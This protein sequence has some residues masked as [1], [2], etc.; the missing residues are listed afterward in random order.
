MSVPSKA[1]VSATEAALAAAEKAS[2]QPTNRGRLIGTAVH[3]ESDALKER[4]AAALEK[5]QTHERKEK[6]M[7]ESNSRHNPAPPEQPPQPAQQTRAETHA[8]CSAPDE[9]GADAVHLL[10]LPVDLQAKILSALPLRS[11]PR[12]Q[13]TCRALKIAGGCSLEA[14]TVLDADALPAAHAEQAVRWLRASRCALRCVRLRARATDGCLQALTVQALSTTDGSASKER[15]GATA[16]ALRELDLGGAEA[17]T[18][19]AL[20]GL[21]GAPDLEKLVL[22]NCRALT[23]RGVELATPLPALT[24]LDLGGTQ[25]GEA[26]TIALARGCPA[27]TS[28]SLRGCRAVGDGG[29]SALGG[30]LRAL[31]QLDL[32]NSALSDEGLAALADGCSALTNLN[33]G[34]CDALTDGGIGAAAA[35][36]ER[37]ERFNL[38]GTAAGDPAVAMV[39]Q[40]CAALHSLNL[41]R[42]TGVTDD[43]A[44]IAVVKCPL[45]SLYLASCAAVGDMTLAAAGDFCATLRE[46]HIAGCAKVTDTGVRAIAAGCADLEVLQVDTCAG[47]TD[48]GIQQLA[49]S[50]P[51]LRA[52]QA[53]QIATLPRPVH[54][55]RHHLSAACRQSAAAASATRRCSRSSST[56][57]ASRASTCAA[58][59][60]SPRWA[61]K[62][63]SGGCR[64]ASCLR[65]GTTPDCKRS[66]RS[67]L[68]D[69]DCTRSSASV[70]L[71]SCFACPTIPAPRRA[72]AWPPQPAPSARSLRLFRCFGELK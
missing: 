34:G 5:A 71:E 17:L 60:A 39:A 62:R 36:L 14:L 16:A 70:G 26:A 6:D 48:D 33:L 52:F 25:A 12:V 40:S 2:K 9:L 47:I 43:G 58:V 45:A 66:I 23:D 41:T 11:L 55:A 42:C 1:T 49:A 67:K 56:A 65:S 19:V 68:W 10:A 50:C 69:R 30:S 64:R 72:H 28:L 38:S 37:L 13:R 29:A 22:T 32:S 54:S 46:L 53:R 59:C 35:R 44:I 15:P 7:T 63:V 20:V 4:A 27:L 51:R 21:R 18:D 8:P 57:R 61:S 31:A 24:T 3:S